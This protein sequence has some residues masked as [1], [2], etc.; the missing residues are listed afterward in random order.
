[1]FEGVIE[2]KRMFLEV[3]YKEHIPRLE[4]ITLYRNYQ[5]FFSTSK[6]LSN[7]MPMLSINLEVY[8]S[9]ALGL[10]IQ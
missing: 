1:M 8:L 10:C 3:C 4:W 9:M 6:F 7:K 5:A 2:T